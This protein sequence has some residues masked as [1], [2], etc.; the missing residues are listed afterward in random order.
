MGLPTE[1]NYCLPQLLV[2][3]EAAVKYVV[4]VVAPHFYVIALLQF[5]CF[6][7]QGYHGRC[8]GPTAV[9]PAYFKNLDYNPSSANFDHSENNQILYEMETHL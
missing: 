2:A 7:A 9:R 6:L 1:I 8:K 3:T 4:V 5:A